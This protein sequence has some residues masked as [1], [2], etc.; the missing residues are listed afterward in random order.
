MKARALLIGICVSLSCFITSF[1]A[2]YDILDDAIYNTASYL[3]KTVKN[4]QVGSIGGE[5]VIIDLARLGCD[6]D[7]SYYQTYYASLEAYV[8]ACNGVLHTKKYTEYSRVILALAS[9]GRDPEKVAGYNLLNALGDYEK[10]IWQGINGPIWA[11]IALDSGNYEIPVNSSAKTQATRD[12]YVQAILSQQLDD[13]GFALSGTS[14]DPDI[15]AMALQ[16]LSKYQ[17]RGDVAAAV[18]KAVACLSK[19]QGETG[20]Y[21]S[22]GT[23]NSESVAQVIV[24]LGELG[25]SID[26]RRFVKNG[27]TLLD[28]L[29]TYYVKEGGFLHTHSK[30]GLNQMATEQA[31][32]ALVAA[33]RMRDGKKSLYR[34]DEEIEVSHV[35]NEVTKSGAGL[36]GKN[37]DVKAVPL[38]APGKTF[39]DI[40]AHV[41]KPAIEALAARGIINGKTD[42]D[43][44]PDTTMT[45]AEFAAIVV[46]GLGLIPKSNNVFDDVPANAWYASYVN[47]AYAYG[48]VSGTSSTCFGP[49]GTITREEAATM[50]TRAARLCGMNID[51]D[52][53]A[54]KDMLAQF[55]DYVK[56]SNWAQ[57]S[58]AFCYSKDILSPKDM[59]ILPKQV[60]K[61]CEIAEMLYR[62]LKKANLF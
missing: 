25:I 61:R 43:F 62:M 46:Q 47:T 22:W 56:S 7:E 4:P 10:T 53:G 30:E 41:N 19:M 50:V 44:D 51:M 15:T 35:I 54:T 36:P 28:N 29:M 5:W 9:I 32:Y 8:K 26:D 60:I 55:S 42:E 49:A 17:N 12:L 37:A 57:S 34:M 39:A 59:E 21:F 38:W 48:I 58:L 2:T 20:G 45:R 52:A 40:S 27:Y 31:F 3:I 1:G 24:A 14:S 23:T 33:Q 16:A 18:D 11:L 13:G 6:V